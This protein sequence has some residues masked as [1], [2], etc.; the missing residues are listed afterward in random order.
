MLKF[1]NSSKQK[2]MSEVVEATSHTLCY[3]TVDIEPILKGM[4][5]YIQCALSLAKIKDMH[6]GFSFEELIGLYNYE[7]A[8]FDITFWLHT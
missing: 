4:K 1:M 5:E 2:K 6:R 3:P 7:K 8:Q